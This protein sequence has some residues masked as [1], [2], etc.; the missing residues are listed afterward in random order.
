MSALKYWFNPK[1]YIK[2]SRG[3]TKLAKW[4]KKV[5]KKNNYTCVACGYQGGG[6]KKLEAHHIVPKSINPR[7]AYRVSNGVTLCSACHRTDE[8]AYHAVNGYKGSHELFNSW[9]SVKRGKVK[10]DDFK[11]NEFLLFFLVILTISLGVFLAYF[12]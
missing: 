9:L 6:S 12:F 1:A 4:A 8:D 7:L 5:Y 10:N 3:S 2:T 11:I